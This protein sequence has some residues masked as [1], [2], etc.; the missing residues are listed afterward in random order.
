MKHIF[1]SNRNIILCSRFFIS[2]IGDAV[3][4]RYHA[5]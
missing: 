2:N 5:Q 3:E 4:A 1:K